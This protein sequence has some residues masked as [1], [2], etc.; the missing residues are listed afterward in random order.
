MKDKIEKLID[1]LIEGRSD[2]LAELGVGE[3]HGK[4]FSLKQKGKT[5]YTCFV[6]WDEDNSEEIDVLANNEREA[7]D[8]ARKVLIAEYKPG[9]K[10]TNVEQRFGLYF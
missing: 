7:K 10:I 8:I 6:A 1:S 9:G 4:Y 3:Y 5:T 2:K